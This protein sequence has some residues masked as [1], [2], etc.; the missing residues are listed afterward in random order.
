VFSLLPRCHGLWIAE[1]DSHVCVRG[2]SDVLRHFLALVP[3][4]RAAQLGRQLGNLAR[5]GCTRDLPEF[6]TRTIA[7][8][9]RRSSN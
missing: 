5:Q 8:M 1:V 6:V 3:G 9:L 4:Q 2:E 7:E